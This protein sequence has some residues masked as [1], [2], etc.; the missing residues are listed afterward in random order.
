MGDSWGSIASVKAE[1]K[2]TQPRM[3][4]GVGGVT[5]EK[6]RRCFRRGEE[7]HAE[8]R[9]DSRGHDGG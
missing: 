5:F 7:K 8:W 1:N 9:G 6:R 2:L 3:S 4:R